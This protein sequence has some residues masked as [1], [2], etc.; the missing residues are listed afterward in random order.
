[1]SN[2]LAYYVYIG[3]YTMG[4][5][6]GIYI[7]QVDVSAGTCEFIGVAPSSDNPSYLTIGPGGHYLYAA[8]EI[9]DFDDK[10]SGAVTSYAIDPAN[11]YLSLANKR[12][13]QGT[14]PCYVSLDKTG[15]YVLVANY[16]GGSIAVLPV[17]KDGSLGEATDCVQHQGHSIDPQRQTGPHPHSIVV[18]PTNR[19]VFVP[20]LGLDKIVAYRLDPRG[21]KLESHPSGTVNTKPGAG[22]RHLVFHP[23]GS[24]AYVINELDST[25][26]A[27]GYESEEGTLRK[28][29]TVSALPTDFDGANTCADIHIHPSGRFLYGSNRGH[30]SLVIYKINDDGTLTYLGNHTALGKNPRNFAIAPS[31]RLL[32]VANQDSDNIVLLA[33][34]EMTG[35]LNPT[36]QVLMVPSPVCIKM[37]G[38]I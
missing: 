8:N 22:P 12:S 25:I 6:V 32:L 35:E 9:A 38:G 13:S 31:G 2:N 1:M 27:Y 24:L 3:T 29:H 36:D 18:D 11:G 7:Y 5:S 14:G 15:K 17:Q 10:A 20:D 19:Y 33:I 4:E 28:L 23:N 30:D 16:G 26:T 34:D 21:G 37:Y